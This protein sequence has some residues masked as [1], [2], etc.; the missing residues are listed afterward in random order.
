MLIIIVIYIF[1]AKD[2][3]LLIGPAGLSSLV[4]TL[5]CIPKVSKEFCLVV[6]SI[7]ISIVP[8]T[9]FPQ[10]AYS[11][12]GANLWVMVAGCACVVFGLKLPFTEILSK[13]IPCG[14]SL[15]LPPQEAFVSFKQATS[16]QLRKPKLLLEETADT[17]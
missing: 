1:S 13:T 3:A 5:P 17:P 14:S 15:C 11:V 16:A 9:F 4:K 6:V 8:L 10:N 12:T 2:D 7:T